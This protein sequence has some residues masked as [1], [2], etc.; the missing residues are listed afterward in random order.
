MHR[1][2]KPFLQHDLPGLLHVGGAIAETAAA[3][4]M[5]MFWSFI[6]AVETYRASNDERPL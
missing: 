6:M 1:G 5:T 2:S 4:T 3:N